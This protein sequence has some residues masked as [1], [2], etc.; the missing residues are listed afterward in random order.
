MFRIF[1]SAISF[2]CLLAAG[3]MLWQSHTLP[4]HFPHGAAAWLNVWFGLFAN[5]I[6]SA[7]LLAG[8]FF[9]AI[10]SACV[11]EMLV[12]LLLT[13][14]STLISALCLLGFMGSHYPSIGEY[15]EKWLR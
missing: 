10:A 8:A 12:G 13:L 2:L 14:L 7:T 15:V 6:M 1:L 9:I 5:P 4:E 11:N 3:L